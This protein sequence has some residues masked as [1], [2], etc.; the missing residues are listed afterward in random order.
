M[1]LLIKARN[2]TTSTLTHKFQRF[3]FVMEWDKPIIYSAQ[4][5]SPLFL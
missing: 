3:L 2:S 4:Y 1:N 5:A